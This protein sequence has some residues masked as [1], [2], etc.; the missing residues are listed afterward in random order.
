LDLKYP[1]SRTI[2]YTQDEAPAEQFHQFKQDFRREVSDRNL[3]FASTLLIPALAFVLVSSTVP[4]TLP[5]AWSSVSGLVGRL[6]SGAFIRV[7]EGG[8]KKDEPQTY[9]LSSSGTVEIEVL[10]ENMLEVNLVAA[11]RPGVIYTVELRRVNVVEGE[12]PVFQA[13]RLGDETQP[14]KPTGEE[15]QSTYRITFTATEPV[16]VIIPSISADAALA[17]IKVKKLPVPKVRL[18]VA[19]NLGDEPWPDDRPLPLKVVATA[20]TP[21]QSISVLIRTQEKTSR[22]LVANVMNEDKSAIDTAYSLLLEPYIDSDFAEVEL[23]AEAVDRSVPDNLVG[24]SNPIRINTVSAYGRYR[25]TL[26]TMRQVKE[27]LDD[28]VGK[29]QDA[30]DDQVKELTDKAVK[31][32]E[33]SPFFDGIDRVQLEQFQAEVDSIHSNFESDRVMQLSSDINDFLFEHEA[34]DDKERDRD[35]FVAIR[36]LSRVVE[37]PVAKRSGSVQTA[38]DRIKRFLDDR[39]RRWKLRV[40]RLPDEYRPPEW[41]KIQSE[42]PFHGGLDF[43]A[44][45]A[46]EDAQRQAALTRLSKLTTEYRDWIE[47]LEK[48]EDQYREQSEQKRQQGLANARDQLKELQK[49]QGEISQ[50]LDRANDRSQ[51]EL[52]GKWPSTKM[53]QQANI[54]DTTSL[55]N[56]IRSLSPAAGERIKVAIDAMKFT[57]ESGNEKKF[58]EAE[59]GSDLAG[60]LLRQADSAAR[61]SQRPQQSGRRRRR[62]TGD[63]YYGQSIVGG[64]IE[65]K[66]DYQVDQRYREEVL[67]EVRQSLNDGNDR[68]SSED[69]RFLEDYLRSV[70]R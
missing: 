34:L 51:D 4:S 39:E 16:H 5:D 45:A 9:K 58:G 30:L 32:S 48:M 11:K 62:V 55:E 52:T 37:Q 70:I 46:K 38:V 63:G 24:L 22:E 21:L 19:T 54:N 27:V 43:V 60:R 15:Q 53:E 40:E 65:I 18:S 6:S 23:V 26:S 31:Q 69:R 57:L 42:R 56:Q 7:L 8:G 1:D 41:P 25:Q 44:R 59:S 2:P 13:F 50:K 64:D 33:D 10:E 20:E 3:R 17:T 14:A 61:K 35:F 68:S 67:N 29:K 28:A 66:R 49:R 12:D 47:S 36:G